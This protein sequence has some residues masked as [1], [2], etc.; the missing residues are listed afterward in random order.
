M[1]TLLNVL[2]KQLKTR[3]LKRKTKGSKK[4]SEEPKTLPVPKKAV[5]ST[6]GSPLLGKPKKEK[7]PTISSSRKLNEACNDF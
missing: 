3:P 6:L 5:K 4:Y 7:K 1:K 2:K